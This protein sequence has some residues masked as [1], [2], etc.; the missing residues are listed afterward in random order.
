MTI[1]EVSKKYN[2]TQDTIRYYERIGL[3]PEIPRTKSGIRDFD[4]KSCKWIEFIKCMRA[5]GMP[6]EALIEYMNLFKQGKKTIVARKQLLIE[7]R[8]VLLK[9][10]EEIKNT[11]EKLDYK[12]ELYNE[13]EAGKRK[14]FMEQP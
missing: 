6:I 13:I 8:D 1:A 2:L 4:E 3:L 9:K 10:Q 14:D 11:I 12:I 5:A 7:Q